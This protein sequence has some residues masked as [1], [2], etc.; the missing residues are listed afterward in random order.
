MVVL[1]E[2]L[3]QQV[4]DL[5]SELNTI[6]LEQYELENYRELFELDEKYPSYDKIAARIVETG[7]QLLLLIRAQKVA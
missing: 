4:S 7:S 2:V 6:K 1:L 3:K 5:T